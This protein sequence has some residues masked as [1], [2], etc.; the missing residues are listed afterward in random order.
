[1]QGL[2]ANMENAATWQPDHGC[3]TFCGEVEAPQEAPDRVLPPRRECACAW[4]R[5]Q[6]LLADVRADTE[7]IELAAGNVVSFWLPNVDSVVGNESVEVE[8]LVRTNPEAA[9]F[10]RNMPGHVAGELRRIA[11]ELIVAAD[12][13]DAAGGKEVQR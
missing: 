1:M 8:F 4:E 2:Y 10:G 11:V 6:R 5:A 13:I 9:I 7:R 3:M 12:R